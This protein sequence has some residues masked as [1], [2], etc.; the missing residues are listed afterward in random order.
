MSQTLL[1]PSFVT[2]R[3]APALAPKSRQRVLKQPGS[4]RRVRS[5]RIT[6]ASIQ[7][8]SEEIW[9]C[10]TLNRNG[11]SPAQTPALDLVLHSLKAKD[12]GAQV[13]SGA[14]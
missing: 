7:T 3:G 14:G 4:V 13:G 5:G 10:M 2:G 6:P 1:S 9:C 11:K 8:R 12:L